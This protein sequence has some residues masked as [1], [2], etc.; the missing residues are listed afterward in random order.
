MN[1]A[2]VPIIKEAKARLLRM[3]YESGVGHIG[4]N[5]SALDAML[6]LHHQVMQAED[7][8]ILSKGHS[9]GALYVTLWTLGKITEEQLVQ[10]HQEETKL[11][12]HPVAGWLP[13]IAFATGSLGH[14]F[15]LAAGVAL[16]KRLKNEAGRVFC[17]T[18]D[19]EWEEGSTWEALIFAAHHQLSN[20]SILI[21]A[22]RLQGFGSTTEVASLEPLSK[23]LSGF[24]IKLW[25]LD[26]HD[27]L[28]LKNKLKK[29]AAKPQVFLLNTIKGHGVS[30]MENQMKWHYLPLSEALYHQ[31]LLDIEKA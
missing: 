6:V 14:G 10:F 4:G 13:E 29:Q 12:G 9:A 20:L 1:K 5:L 28:S 24:D 31:A 22:N 17:L 23:K 7:E 2:I 26:G 3:H 18:S 19:G 8:F 27:P 11:A 21:D 25:E 16:A 15:S 30:F